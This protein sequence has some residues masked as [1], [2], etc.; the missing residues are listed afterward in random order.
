VWED[1]RNIMNGEDI[2][3]QHLSSDGTALWGLDGIAVYSGAGSQSQP[4]LVFSPDSGL[5]V[6]WE[7]FR[8]SHDMDL[9][10]QRIDAAGN[11]LWPEEGLAICSSQGD[12]DRHQLLLN[13]L[14]GFT[15]AWTDGREP[16]LDIYGTDVRPDGS[17][18]REWWVEGSGGRIS[19]AQHNQYQPILADF[20]DHSALVVWE[21]LRASTIDGDPYSNLYMQRILTGSDM[22]SANETPQIPLAY[23]LHQNYPNPF[24]PTTTISFFIAKAGQVSLTVYDLLGRSVTTLLNERLNSGSYQVPW[25]AGSLP[26]GMYF[27][28]LNAD[29]FSDV[30]KTVLLK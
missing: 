26:S 29:G 23:A 14:G 5:Y 25:D 11:L 22:E 12:Q 7:D 2:Y 17:T 15:C 18:I 8:S 21:D 30:K 10:A 13:N 27:Y 6:V 3:A 24:N 16:Y 9:Y 28:R 19:M 4:R 20:S 1:R